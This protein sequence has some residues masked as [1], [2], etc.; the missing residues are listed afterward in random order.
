M[1]TNSIQL[2]ELIILEVFLLAVNNIIFDSRA[3][4]RDI[5]IHLGEFDTKDTGRHYEPLPKESFG[6]VEKK[7]HPNFKYM[8]TQPDRY[9]KLGE[10]CSWR[11]M[12]R[13]I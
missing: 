6:V 2:N 13:K 4:L 12:L 10:L 11:A 7:T 5:T 8:L 9:E 1:D 3:R